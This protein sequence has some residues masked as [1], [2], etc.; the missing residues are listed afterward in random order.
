MFVNKNPKTDLSARI[1]VIAPP[2]RGFNVFIGGTTFSKILDGMDQW[3]TK[4][5]WD[6][7]GFAHASKKIC[8]NLQM[9]G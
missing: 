4:K 2:R 8:N 3:I 1:D 6:E 7:Q 9:S 5:E